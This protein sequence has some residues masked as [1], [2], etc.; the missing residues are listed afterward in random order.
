M[1]EC[2]GAPVVKDQ[3]KHLTF[4]QRNADI[5]FLETHPS[6]HLTLSHLTQ[7]GLATLGQVVTT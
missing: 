5:F 3:G 1:S 7:V 4:L 2:I 6:L